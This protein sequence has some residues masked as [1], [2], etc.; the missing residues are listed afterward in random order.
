MSLVKPIRDSSGDI[1]KN[2]MQKQATAGDIFRLDVREPGKI[3]T[4]NILANTT[5]TYTLPWHYQVGQNQ[6]L[7][8]A[9]NATTGTS[10]RF[11]LL[12]PTSLWG[13]GTPY[14]RYD[15]LTSN[16][17]TVYNADVSNAYSLVFLIPH[18]STPGQFASKVVV[19]PQGD[20]A[21]IELLGE[22]DGII[23]KSSPSGNKFLMRVDDEGNIGVQEVT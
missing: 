22:G 18:T 23:L 6:L 9:M 1:I 14:L 17:V 11:S 21:G 2:A 5:S 4:N 8:F 16:T 3:Y 12:L 20:R 13:S 10:G 7:V 15:E 19:D